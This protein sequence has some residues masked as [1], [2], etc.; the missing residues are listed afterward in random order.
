MLGMEQVRIQRNKHV[1]LC[2]PDECGKSDIDLGQEGPRW[3]GVHVGLL[4][5][6]L[7]AA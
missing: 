5:D 6:R 1:D 2:P 3:A 4:S 7:L